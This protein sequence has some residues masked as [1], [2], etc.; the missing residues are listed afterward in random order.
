MFSNN[1]NSWS[2]GTKVEFTNV[3]HEVM[4]SDHRFAVVPPTTN[5]LLPSLVFYSVGP[6][7][8]LGNV[9]RTDKFATW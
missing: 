3:P 8:V 4:A 9:V 1:L 5:F 6:P 7:K 2:L